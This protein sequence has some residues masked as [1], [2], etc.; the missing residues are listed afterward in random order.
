MTKSFLIATVA[1]FALTAPAQAADQ[2]ERQTN[3]EQ[4][5]KQKRGDQRATRAKAQP[6][7]A[8]RRQSVRAERP[9]ARAAE[10][11]QSVRAERPQA[12]Q[13]VRAQQ[14]RAQQT[15]VQARKRVEMD[16]PQVRKQAQVERKAPRGE[17]RVRVQSRPVERRT[18]L[19]QQIRPRVERQRVERDVRAQRNIRSQGR[20]P[21]RRVEV[22]QR[23][24]ERF[25]AQQQR[26]AQV[27]DR[28]DDRF[29]AQRKLQRQLQAQRVNRNERIDDRQDM[30]RAQQRLLARMAKPS[31]NIG[32][33]IDLRQ[34]QLS[35]DWYDDYRARRYAR[36]APSTRYVYD[37]N[38]NDGYLYKVDRQSN[39]I[40]ALF[41]LL[42]GAFSVAQPMPIGFNSYNVPSAYRS[43]YYDTP[44]TQFRYGD[45]AIYRVDPTTQVIQTVV[46]LLTGQNLRVGQM[47]PT[48]YDVY[49]VPSA[50]RQR[51]VDRDDMW[52]RYNDG[53]IYGV[54]PYSRQIQSMYPMSYGG[55]NVGYPAPSYASYGGYTGYGSY[56]GYPSNS[57]PYGYNQLYNSQP[58]YNYQYANGGVYQVDPTTQLVSALVALVTGTN[59]GIGQQLPRGYDVYNVPSA[60]RASY[61]D[62]PNAMYRYN[63][64]NIYQVDPYSRVIQASI[65]VSYGGYNVGYPVPSAYPGYAVPNQY[66]G[67]YN[68]APGYDYRY[69]DG[70][71]YAVN[72]QTQIV[73][74]QVALLTGNTFGVGQMLPAGY[75]A[76]NVPFAY[77]DRY[78]D[79][80]NSM[81]RYADGN[82]YQVDPTTRLIQAVIDAIV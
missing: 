3:G 11:R 28:N 25:R 44:N 57:V 1:A 2:R 76:Y 69:S 53:N 5:A 27:R 31:R 15:R 6:R 54:D 13:K 40:A 59:L 20:G 64:G 38:D 63:D 30:R 70:G 9:K 73:Q 67:L 47:L 14:I 56:G 72:P 61:F 34:R 8:E 66:A 77:R 41:P 36:L 35:R 45:G 49:N 22:Q 62:T 74:S 12:R 18:K 37:Y 48:G 58:G 51:F 19:V 42:G 46:A 75:D 32:D 55:Y 39:A 33:R 21:E 10:R 50:Y 68:A 71:I 23:N 82:I 79:T 60:Y 17:T 43:L 24:A 65:P 26:L 7:A 81:Y 78:Y 4:R 80:P 29:E 52:Y 16:R